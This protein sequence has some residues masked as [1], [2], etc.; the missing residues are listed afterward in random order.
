[1]LCFALGASGFWG[2]HCRQTSHLRSRNQTW[3]VKAFFIPVA[4]V[5]YAPHHGPEDC[6]SNHRLHCN[7]T[8]LLQGWSETFLRLAQVQ[9]LCLESPWA[10]SLR[11]IVMVQYLWKRHTCPSWESR[12]NK[13]PQ[14]QCHLYTTSGLNSCW[15]SSIALVFSK[16]W[17]SD[18][19]ERKTPKPPG[20]AL[21]Q[22]YL[23]TEMKV[24][25][26]Y[27]L[28]TVR[29]STFSRDMPWSREDYVKFDKRRG[30]VLV[31]YIG[32]LNLRFT[33]S[34]YEIERIL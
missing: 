9:C 24:I 28:C 14:M 20:L 10:T 16:S 26:A 2:R 30:D 15:E 22:P 7:H 6:F 17:R 34:P 19:R 21:D 29:C 12:S 18:Y 4:L 31:A 1:M 11:S 32:P 3:L 5:K 23:C 25:L 13:L 8:Q 27:F 33:L